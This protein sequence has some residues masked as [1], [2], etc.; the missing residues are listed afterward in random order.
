MQSCEEPFGADHAYVPQRRRRQ[1][2]RLWA[3]LSAKVEQ[4]AW[5]IGNRDSAEL[6]PEDWNSLRQTLGNQKLLGMDLMAGGHLTHGFRKTFP[7]DVQCRQLRGTSGDGPD[8]FDAGAAGEGSSAAILLTGYGAIPGESISN[9]CGRSPTLS[10][11]SSW[12]TWPISQDW[13]RESV[14]DLTIRFHADVVTTTTTRR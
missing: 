5:I 12:W 13:C 2:G 3:I 4:P 9:A 1:P 14:P 6:S 8:D 10:A 7:R 11:P